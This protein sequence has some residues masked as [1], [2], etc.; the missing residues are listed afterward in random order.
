MGCFYLSVTA[1]WQNLTKLKLS[2][3]SIIKEEVASVYKDLSISADQNGKN[4]PISIYV[5]HI[6]SSSQ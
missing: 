6:L 4:S 5:H 3:L 2:I 1:K